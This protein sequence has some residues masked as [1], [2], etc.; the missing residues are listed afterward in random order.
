MHRLLY[1]G[2]RMVTFFGCLALLPTEA[3]NSIMFM[4][5]NPPNQPPTFGPL[6][7]DGN[8][9]PLLIGTLYS[10]P[11][12][13]EVA[14]EVQG[15]PWLGLVPIGAT[16]CSQ[17]NQFLNI[18]STPAQLSACIIDA[19]N[20]LIANGQANLFF[21]AWAT[22]TTGSGLPNTAIAAPIRVSP[23]SDV[24]V[25]PAHLEIADCPARAT[26][27]V[28]PSDTLTMS[29]MSYNPTYNPTDATGWLIQNA[30]ENCRNQTTCT[31]KVSP[32][33]AALSSPRVGQ[34]YHANIT[35]KT[36]GGSS[37][38]LDVEYIVP[39]PPKG[40]FHERPSEESLN[41]SPPIQACWESPP[42]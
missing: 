28:G 14:V 21:E 17:A 4:P 3:Q 20:L 25:S 40:T 2:L 22:G 5:A 6:P 36:A 24:D 27:S 8:L 19:S 29:A 31:V 38:Q 39:L 18:V 1:A 35:F 37:G 7:G 12:G 10:S 26:V 16:D 9:G 15:E 23:S 34:H 32:N 30:A 42:E 11:S 41:R 33:P 13:E